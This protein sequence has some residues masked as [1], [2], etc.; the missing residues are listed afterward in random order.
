MEKYMEDTEEYRN[1]DKEKGTRKKKSE[2][3][4]Q[5]RKEDQREE[6]CNPPLY[7]REHLHLASMCTVSLPA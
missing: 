7:Q 3:E 4:K 5:R 6:H 1:R 2:E